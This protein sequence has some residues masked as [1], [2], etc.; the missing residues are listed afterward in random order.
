MEAARLTVVTLVK[1]LGVPGGAAREVVGLSRLGT[2]CMLRMPSLL[3]DRS[4]ERC[5]S[6]EAR[7][8]CSGVLPA[9]LLPLRSCCA[10]CCCCTACDWLRLSGGTQEPGTCGG[11]GDARSADQLATSQD[12]SA[13][14]SLNIPWPSARNCL[15]NCLKKLVRPPNTDYR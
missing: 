8:G 2:L 15:C 7:R 4:P 6:G 3:I 14:T 9:E 11:A 1:V 13:G 12:N 5:R 10:C